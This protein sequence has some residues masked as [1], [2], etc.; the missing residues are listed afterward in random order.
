VE[1]ER[2]RPP[3]GFAAAIV[4]VEVA[5]GAVVMVETTGL[6]VEAGSPDD[7][8]CEALGGDG[9]RVGVPSAAGAGANE[10]GPAGVLGAESDLVMTMFIFDRSR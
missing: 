4:V 7:G 9:G 2:E 1:R 8:P 3:W 5:A 10:E 6:D